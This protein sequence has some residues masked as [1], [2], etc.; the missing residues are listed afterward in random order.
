MKLDENTLA[1]LIEQAGPDDTLRPEHQRQLREQSLAAF[2]IAQ[3]KPT[4]RAFG[5]TLADYGRWIVRSPISRVA[6]MIV[7]VV[8]VGGVAIWFYGGGA[9]YAFAD[10]VAPILEAKT[11]KF[12]ITTEMKGQ[13]TL[14]SEVMVLDA[15]R[16]RQEAEMPNKTKGITITDFTRGKSLTLDPASKKALVITY[17]GLTKK[18]V[19]QQNMFAQFRSILLDARDKPGIK[20]EP[21]GEKEIDGRRVVGFRVKMVGTELSLWGDPK[22][23][24]PVRV[25][26]TVGLYGNTRVTMSDFVFN[27]PM[28]E[29]LFSVEP[30]AGYT[31][32]NQTVDASPA[33]EKDLIGTFRIYCEL[34]GGVFP[35]S[36][37]TQPMMM[38]VGMRIGMM[39]ASKSAMQ[40]VREKLASGKQKLSEEQIRKVEEAMDK[41][42]EWQLDSAK[43]PNEEE[44]RKTVG[45]KEAMEALAGGKGKLSE[46]EI[47]KNAQAA[48]A[49]NSEAGMK[50]FMKVQTPLQRGLIFVFTLPANADAHY[51]GKGVTT[52]TLDR[53]IFWYKPTGAKT[54]RVIFADLS[55]RDA[56][57][58]P[59]VAGA[60]AVPAAS[61][62]EKK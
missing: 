31:V 60:Q 22:T 50:E 54:Y 52:G 7:L 16:Q 8:A 6:A 42:L 62:G 40:T 45:L 18:Q 9:T 2:D 11:A 53:P 32:Q 61:S 4:R 27:V 26:Q 46:E 19:A 51:A 57:M 56:E 29:S 34:C 30:P 38:K 10:F 3:A 12:K 21:L 43:K 59:K 5:P 33:T 23:G 37:D 44:L 28:D 48:A 55:V 58:P 25:E 15:A 17:A 36:L 47:H 49:K 14:T 41:I 20:R 39:V 1:R 13:P 35:D 24:L